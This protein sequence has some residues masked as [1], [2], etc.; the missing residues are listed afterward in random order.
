MPG[1]VKGTAIVVVLI[2]AFGV[3]VVLEG[4]VLAAL[5]RASRRSPRL[6]FGVITLYTAALLG[7]LGAFGVLASI[8]HSAGHAVATSVTLWVGLLVVAP[9]AITIMPSGWPY[10]VSSD[11]R[12]HGASRPVSHVIAWC[13]AVLFFVLLMP[14]LGGAGIASLVVK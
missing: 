10:S 6:A 3:S 9:F 1:W 14:A 2:A 12:K 7:V 13:G 4:R 5:V 8:W 11:L